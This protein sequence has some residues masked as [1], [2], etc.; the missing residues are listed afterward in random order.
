MRGN[1]DNVKD[2]RI[3]LFNYLINY[4][5]RN[6]NK[7]R[8]AVTLNIDQQ[9]YR[10]FIYVVH[11]SFGCYPHRGLNVLIEGLMN[12]VIENFKTP[13]AIQTT[14]FYKPK[15]EKVEVKQQFNLAQK[16]EIKLVKQDLTYILDRLKSGKGDKSF[17]LERLRE[18]LP[19]AIRVYQKTSDKTIEKLL[20]K[21]ERWI[22]SG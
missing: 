14:L 12:L 3:Q 9:V 20:E 2:F 21:S 15:I 6:K 22:E 10:Q 11:K 16:L 19:K 7:N 4:L 1:E 8:N 18:V 5:I 13:E 17:Y